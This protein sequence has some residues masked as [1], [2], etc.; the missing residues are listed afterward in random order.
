MSMLRIAVPLGIVA[1]VLLL[2]SL[3]TVS[4]RQKAILFQLGE[5]VRSDYE[6]GLH[7]KMPFVNNVR[8]FDRRLLSLDTQP[9]RFLTV[10]K[11]DV[12]VDYYVRWR[13]MDVELFYRAAGG[14]ERRAGLLMFQKLNSALRDEFSTRTVQEV[15]SGERQAIMDTATRFADEEVDELGIDIEDVRV[16]RIDLPDEVSSSVYQRMRA[17][18]E[19]VARD[20]RARGAEEAEKIR[21]GADRERTIILADAYR[22]SQELR[23]TGD[24]RAA[25]TYAEAFGSNEEFFSLYRSLNAYRKSFEGENNVMILAPDSKFF[26]YLND[27]SPR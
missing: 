1:L 11:K 10:E 15:V 7:F 24:A 2:M 8:K 9:E 16:S 18:R 12:I 4:E 25:D 3:F 26:K 6:P 20:F 27:P 21:A 5:I 13:I 23:G 22:R 17:E 19:R 14:D